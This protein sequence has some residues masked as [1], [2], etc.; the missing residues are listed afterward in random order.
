MASVVKEVTSLPG[1]PSLS[2]LLEEASGAALGAA[3]G[4]PLPAGT[5]L[6][7][8]SDT[9][10][11]LSTGPREGL[12]AARAPAW[13][14]TWVQTQL[15]ILP[16]FPP[17]RSRCARRGWSASCLWHRDYPSRCFL[18]TSPGHCGI[19]SMTLEA[20]VTCGKYLQPHVLPWC[21]HAPRPTRSMCTH[22]GTSSLILEAQKMTV[23]PGEAWAIAPHDPRLLN[24]RQTLQKVSESRPR[25]CEAVLIL[26]P[27][28]SC[29]MGPSL[30]PTG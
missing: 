16:R 30:L 28:L 7:A 1:T 27:C 26:N 24:P 13:K 25:R 12:C 9:T 14:H 15:S 5:G 3:D 10:A 18:Q 22:V 2:P 8:H 21:V 20:G 23:P 19:I 11:P 29:V 4:S 6:C 17:R